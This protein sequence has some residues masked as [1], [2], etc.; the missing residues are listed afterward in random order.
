MFGGIKCAYQESKNDKQFCLPRG[1]Q[2]GAETCPIG[3][4]VKLTKQKHKA[5]FGQLRADPAVDQN[6]EAQDSALY[7]QYHITIIQGSFKLKEPS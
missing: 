4:C 7:C 3:T 2:L 1:A 6:T 5:F